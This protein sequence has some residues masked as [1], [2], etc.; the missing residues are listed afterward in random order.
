MGASV[1]EPTGR[2]GRSLTDQPQVAVV[3]CVYNDQ[4][5]V[6][7]AI[8]SV[9]SQTLRGIEVIVVD[10][11]STD[12][13]Y[14]YLA[15]RFAEDS[16]V[17]IAQTE[18]NTGG[19]GGP[20]NVGVRLARA[21]YVTFL[22]SDDEL[23]R[24]A[25]YNLLHAAE[26]YASDISMGRTR[27]YNIGQK[28]F[29]GWHH[30]LFRDEYYLKTIEYYPEIGIDTIA[31]AKLFRMDYLEEN[32]LIFREGIHY[33]DLMFTAEAFA[34]AQGIAVIPESV[35]QWNVY[36]QPERKS[37]TNQRDDIKN[38]RD[39]KAAI[40][41]VMSIVRE[42]TAPRLRARLQLK[43]LRHDARLYLNDIADGKSRKIATEMLGELQELIRTVPDSVF[44][45]LPQAERL[46]M[47]S[48]LVGD[49]S[50]I[51]R[52]VNIARGEYDLYGDWT[53]EGGEAVWEPAVFCQCPPESL[54]RRLAT[55][56]SASVSGVPWYN[57]KW[58][59]TASSVTID[60]SNK[61]AIRGATPDSFETIANSEVH[62]RVVLREKTGAKRGWAFPA[63]HYVAS[64]SRSVSWAAEFEFPADI[65]LAR[66]P[67]MAVHLELNDGATYAAQSI[68][69]PLKFN[70]Q[71]R[72]TAP[73]SRLAKVAN[74]RYRPYRSKIRT[75][76]FR[77]NPVTPRRKKLRDFIEPMLARHA[78]NI[79]SQSMQLPIGDRAETGAAI[80][81]KSAKPLRK[82]LVVVES[83]M[84]KSNH[85]SPRAVADELAVRRPDLDIIWVADAG[86]EWSFGRSDI[87]VRH[88]KAYYETLATAKYIIDNQSLPDGYTKRDGQIYLQTWHGIPLK[89]MGFDEDSMLFSPQEKIDNLVRKVRYWDYLTVPS[90]YFRQSFVPAYRYDGELLPEGSPRNDALVKN[91]ALTRR[92]KRMLGLDVDRTTV[93]YA[94]TFRQVGTAGIELDLDDLVTRLGKD[95]QLLVRPHY[96]NRMKIPR[97]MRSDVID[98]SMVD[99]TNKVLLASDVL[100]TDYSSIMFDYLVLD[101]PIVLYTYDYDAYTQSTRGTY[102]ELKQQAPGPLA[103]TQ[104]D[105]IAELEELIG[106]ND[107]YRA[108]RSDFTTRFGGNETGIS[109]QNTVSTVWGDK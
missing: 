79:D 10:D 31:V 78:E 83:H 88:T 45:E 22:D 2:A 28:R 21:P 4:T 26:R 9:L 67:R 93:L 80:M 58:N 96:L 41:K 100:I 72:K 60:R 8:D 51:A 103:M 47:A 85:D 66:R 39:R 11:C 25:C 42:E 14:E 29:T 20:R 109:A 82:N 1:N 108:L 17:T 89:K 40:G 87:V 90:D 57:V 107:A 102:F 36:P 74:V 73:T 62:F 94:P 69:V 56:N 53:T 105:L 99:D 27:R 16:K 3:I 49:Q 50:L 61:V 95:I 77:V 98:V 54:E 63:K 106:G 65:D 86:Q 91:A 64:E 52:T 15:E 7:N 84:G 19:P 43:I 71:D 97:E 104:D 46:L 37:I 44:D 59:H 92:Y 6:L 38:L 30:R 34:K 81:A 18:K 23:E 35:Y 76:G 32:G 5:N 12:G 33:E 24:H 13:T 48:A 70:V 68:R 101:R 55:F 75:L